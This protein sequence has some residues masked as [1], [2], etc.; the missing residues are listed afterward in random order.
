[1][2]A[3]ILQRRE[4]EINAKRREQLPW[5]VKDNFHEYQQITGNVKNAVIPRKR[6]HIATKRPVT[7]L[8]SE[9]YSQRNSFAS[10]RS[11]QKCQVIINTF[12][13]SNFTLVFQAVSG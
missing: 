8:M 5:P 2:R 6:G 4:Q 12:S 13:K 7:G 9:P 10:E 1:M 11:Y 3:I